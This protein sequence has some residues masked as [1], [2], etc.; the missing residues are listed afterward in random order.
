MKKIAAV[1][2][3]FFCA[4]SL[5]AQCPDSSDATLQETTD[6]LVSKIEAYGGRNIPPTRYEVKFNASQM[7]ITEFGVDINLELKDTVSVVKVNLKNLD[8][9]AL[10]SHPVG[11]S[12]TRYALTINAKE[13]KM[14]YRSPTLG[15][16]GTGYEM[17][18]D[19]SKESNLMMRMVKALKHGYC[20][21]GG[22]TVKE[23]F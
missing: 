8:L 11:K 9:D 19:C 14:S 3:L 1:F 6:W 5:F 16:M 13:R 20:L 4:Q 7:T 18:F 21:S 12:S 17:I 2:L 22:I 15:E 23:K 10:E